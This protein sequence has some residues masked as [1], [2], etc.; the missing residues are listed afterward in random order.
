MTNVNIS[1]RGREILRNKAVSSAIARALSERAH[2]AATVGVWV[3][4]EGKKY[5]IKT[6]SALTEKEIAAMSKR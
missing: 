4:V 1:K 2:E 6:A 3:E 5:L